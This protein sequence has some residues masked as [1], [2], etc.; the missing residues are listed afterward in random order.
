MYCLKLVMSLWL[1][2]GLV[3]QA[4]AER[5]DGI[6]AV[7]NGEAVTCSEVDAAYVAL[8]QQMEQQ[9]VSAVD[10][11]VV[12]QRALE[13]RTMRLLQ[14]QQ[15]RQLEL[16]ISHEEVDAAIQDVESRNNLLPGQLE[17]ALAAQGVDMIAY[18]ETLEYK[19]LS[20]RLINIAVR[21]K[22]SVSEEAM[23]EYY[24][25]YLKE[26]QAVREVR[27]AQL[28]FALPA[29]ASADVV[30]SVR[31]KAQGLRQNILA[32]EPFARISAMASDAPNAAEG[33]DMGWV[34]PGAVAGAFSQIFDLGLG[35]LSEV[36]RSAAGFHVLTVTEDRVQKPE[37][38]QPYEEVH[39]R[40]IL[41]QIP[42]SAD[43]TTQLKIHERATQI[44]Q[45][46][47][48]AS[49]EAFA[50]RAKELSQGP[51]AQRGGDLGWF[52]RGQM[53]GSFDDAVF[54][55]Q[56]GE[57]SDVVTTQFGLH[58]IRLVERRKV[59]PNAFEAHQARIEQLL[60]DTEMQQQVPRW[61]EEI[62]NKATITM[63][64]CSDYSGLSALVR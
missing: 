55:M 63:G 47:Q 42:E 38:M 61:M 20:S 28:F 7:V 33:G 40:H 64:D 8:Y 16:K 19:L 49:D 24:R 43:L 12:M 41:I 23:R 35:Q 1:L 51:S 15:A 2:M 9:G 10:K 62:K 34:S 53:V 57:T 25:K 45:E 18:R 11:K 39:A 56:P 14:Y 31:I 30:E 4:S 27:V 36:I 48:G 21:S 58:V 44:S 17:A 22:V 37:N 59:N 29:D 3:V 46:M 54:A 26:P 50:V 60:T 13:A 52:K 32:G 5:L 6:A